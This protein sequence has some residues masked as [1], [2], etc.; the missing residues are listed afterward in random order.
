MIHFLALFVTVSILVIFLGTK[1]QKPSDRYCIAA[2]L[3]IA[4]LGITAVALLHGQVMFPPA[5]FAIALL[6]GA[7][8]MV[9]HYNSQAEEDLCVPFRCGRDSPHRTWI[10][11][12]VVAG[13]TSAL[14]I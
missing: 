5:A 10:V 1:Q 4:L 9:T 12:A 11:A 8:H 14:R 7:H 3:L 2:A 6:I 13:T